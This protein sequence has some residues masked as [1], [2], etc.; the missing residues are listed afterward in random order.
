[1]I[2]RPGTFAGR[3]QSICWKLKI[4]KTLFSKKLKQGRKYRNQKNSSGQD[5]EDGVEHFVNR[6]QYEDQEHAQR[7]AKHV[8][9][10]QPQLQEDG[11]Y[12]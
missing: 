4:R 9:D 2:T 12:Q 5:I 1:M 8:H 7:L 10:L 3:Q 11:D 6:T